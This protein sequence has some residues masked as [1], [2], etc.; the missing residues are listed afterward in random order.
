LGEHSAKRLSTRAV[1]A[2]LQVRLKD[3]GGGRQDRAEDCRPWARGRIWSQGL[4]EGREAREVW[5]SV[6]LRECDEYGGHVLRRWLHRPQECGE[7]GEV[8]DPADAGGG[9]WGRRLWLRRRELRLQWRGLRLAHYEPFAEQCAVCRMGGLSALYRG[10]AER[11]RFVLV[12]L[13]CVGS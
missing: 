11:V 4:H 8:G 9:L 1:C 5:P 10:R 6:G 3:G 12:E 2:R 7:L 13:H